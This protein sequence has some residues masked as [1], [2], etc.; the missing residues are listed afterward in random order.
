MTKYKQFLNQIIAGTNEDAHGERLPKEFFEKLLANSPA[1][2]PLHQHHD[3]SL[4]SLGYLENFRLVPDVNAPGEWY[5]LADIFIRSDDVDE[6]LKGFSFSAIETIGGNTTNPEIFIHLPYPLYKDQKLVGEL[7]K[8]DPTL[9]VGR[10]IKKGLDP[11]A[12]G[13]ITAGIVLLLGPEWDKQYKEHIRPRLEK[14]FKKILALKNKGLTSIDLIQHVVGN[15]GEQI[16][17]YFIPDRSD[18]LRSLEDIYIIKGLNSVRQFLATD[19]RSQ[20]L[21]VQRIN[22]YYDTYLSSYKIFSVEYLDGTDV[23]IA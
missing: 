11:T 17:V 16:K 1:R 18:E 5:V 23:N 20:S 14:L 7:I 9:L 22:L 4:P 2:A 6:A 19:M 10:W 13:L 3:P 8:S 15:R 12:I 21:G